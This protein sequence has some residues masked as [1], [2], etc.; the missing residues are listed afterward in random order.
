M[1]KHQSSPRIPRWF[2]AILLALLLVGYTGNTWTTYAQQQDPSPIRMNVRA[3][4]DGH[5]RISQ[6]YPVEVV[7]QNDGPDVRGILEWQDTTRSDDEHIFQ[8]EIDLPRGSHKRITF[9][10]YTG[11]FARLMELRLRSGRTILFQQQVSLEPISHDQTV[12]GVVS[13][14][15]TVLRSLAG[16]ELL[17]GNATTVLHLKTDMI[18]EQAR[19]FDTLDVLFLHE[20]APLS[21][22]QREALD[23]WVHLGGTL[24]VSGGASGEQ[25][26]TGL[27]ALLPVTIEGLR[28]DVPLDS[29][30]KLVR[31]RAEQAIQ[32]IPPTTASDVRVRDG[33]N[34]LDGNGL[35]VAHQRGA[36]RVIFTAF[37]LGILRAW[38][39]ETG[40]W[41][42]VLRLQ[43]R[44]VP[45][46]P[47]S[48]SGSNVI[49]NA[50]HLPELNLPSLW[51]LLLFVISYIVIVGPANF[52]ILRYFKRAELAWLTVPAIVIIFVLGT[53]GSSFLIRG[54]HPEVVQLSVV[55][56]FEGYEQAQMTGYIG[57]FS[58][59]RRE[60]TLRFP[61]AP[62]VRTAPQFDSTSRDIRVQ[63]NDDTSELQDVL[64]DVSSLRTFVTEATITPAPT[65]RS[66]LERT[67][68]RVTGDIQNTS[69]TTLHQTIVVH[70]DDMHEIG[71]LAPGDTQ[72]VLIERM[73]SAF[74][75]S[76]TTVAEDDVF[77][78]S[79]V[80]SSFF[81]YQRED[82]TLPRIFTETEGMIDQDGV[83]LL[84]WEETPLVDIQVGN[85]MVNQ[86]GYGLHIIRLNVE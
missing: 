5:Y 18:P 36:G 27:D 14:D 68:G 24:V 55:Q 79:T 59:R 82:F 63:W 15:S 39:G 64:I 54:N 81:G 53:Y 72:T 33:A 3:G 35:V 32:D 65:V 70:G 22:A 17:G 69:N 19:V 1:T 57:V 23:L 11:S 78:R 60:Y 86:Q 47:P 37:D 58:P 80:I 38:I 28:S 34:N 77:H 21:E 71:T 29:L 62:L 9:N 20:S 76:I 4:F 30:A 41:N 8:Q 51:V 6:W 73:G 43:P 50:L 75:H 49:N 44:F 13:S 56:S 48:W 7:I 74:P 61:K 52:L 26:T 66:A 12:V 83:Y 25:T 42:N 84:G 85:T 10:A 40:M 31:G 46:A 16:V 2:R 45:S 67:V